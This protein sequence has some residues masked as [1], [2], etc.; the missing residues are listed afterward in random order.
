MGEMEDVKIG[1]GRDGRR[2]DGEWARWEKGEIE[3]VEIGNVEMGKGRDGER[4]DR[5]WARWRT[6]R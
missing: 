1:N 2:R 4:R 3:N 6:S 5:E